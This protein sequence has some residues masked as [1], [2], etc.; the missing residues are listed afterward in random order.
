MT[1]FEARA[2]TESKM[3]RFFPRKFPCPLIFYIPLSLFPASFAFLSPFL[4]FFCWAFT[5]FPF[6]GKRFCEK[7]EDREYF[8]KEVRAGS[9]TRIFLIKVTRCFSS[10]LACLTESRSFGYGLKDLISLH[11]LVVKVV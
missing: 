10:S 1:A 8:W 2:C 11:K 6:G 4:F 7:F 9:G 3:S 5:R